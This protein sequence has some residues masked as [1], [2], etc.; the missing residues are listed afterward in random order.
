MAIVTATA[1]A[2][3]TDQSSAK[4]AKGKQATSKVKRR[5]SSAQHNKRPTTK[6]GMEKVVREKQWSTEAGRTSSRERHHNQPT[7][8]QG[9]SKVARGMMQA[10]AKLNAIFATL[11]LPLL[12]VV[13]SA[14]ALGSLLPSSQRVIHRHVGSST[15][16]LSLAGNV[17]NMLA[18][19]CPNTRCCSNFGQMGP[20]YQH[21][22]EMLAPVCVSL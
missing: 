6:R 12:I 11:T 1:A 15:L 16:L 17:A 7:T 14:A 2:T 21:K 20:C 9:S 4:D 19:C 22:I 8:E 18:T 5:S 3:T 10:T 13:S